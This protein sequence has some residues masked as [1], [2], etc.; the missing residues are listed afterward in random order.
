MARRGP[1]GLGLKARVGA[2][3]PTNYDGVTHTTCRIF[4]KIADF[5]EN[6]A[7]RRVTGNLRIFL[8]NEKNTVKIRD[9]YLGAQRPPKEIRILTK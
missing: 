1:R 6:T 8:R 4:N 7:C 3:R 9:F 5:V 2:Q